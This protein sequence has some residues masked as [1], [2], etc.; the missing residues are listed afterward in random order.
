MKKYNLRCTK[1]NFFIYLIHLISKPESVD[2]WEFD[3][4]RREIYWTAL[5][6]GVKLHHKWRS[7]SPI[8]PPPPPPP[9]P[10]YCNY[11]NIN[12]A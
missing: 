4:R 8:D 6:I 12:K 5:M 3:Q 9:P 2:F 7:P 1:N 11:A 10:M